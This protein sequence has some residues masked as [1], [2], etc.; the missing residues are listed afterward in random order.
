[1]TPI[2]AIDMNRPDAAR[3]VG[4]ELESTA[5]S[6]VDRMRAQ[7]CGVYQ[8][9]RDYVAGSTVTHNGGLWRATPDTKSTAFVITDRAS[10]EQVT[11]DRATVYALIKR[12]EEFFKPLK[13]LAHRLHAELCARELEI[14]APLRAVDREQADAIRAFHQ[15]EDAARRARERE[16]AEAQRLE[17][18]ARAVAAAAEY[19]R[20][21]E[22]HTAAAVLAEA[23]AAP[24]PVVVI[25][26]PNRDLVTFTRR[27]KWKYAGGPVEVTKTPAE[28]L[29][30]TLAILPD[31]FKTADEK[32]IG[33]YARSMKTSGRIPGIDIYAVDEPNR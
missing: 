26:D 8:D 3:L 1:M 28:I 23:I 30:R 19:E 2:D 13:A 21:G 27:W 6:T 31:E 18:E 25:P 17:D 9:G 20:A 33:A 29:R 4:R 7:Y 24:P 32:K 15:V 11:E 14:L 12:A 5:L 22:H 10:L 16:A